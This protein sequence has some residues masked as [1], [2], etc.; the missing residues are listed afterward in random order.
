MLY[1]APPMSRDGAL[2]DLLAFSYVNRD[3]LWIHTPLPHSHLRVLS[4]A[5]KQT[6]RL[7]PEVTYLL[8][9][10]ID[11]AILV[12]SLGLVL[13]LLDLLL[14]FLGHILLLLLLGQVPLPNGREV[15]L[16]QALDDVVLPKYFSHG[17]P[18]IL[19]EG[20]LFQVVRLPHHGKRSHHFL[21]SWSQFNSHPI[22]KHLDSVRFIFGRKDHTPVLKGG[23]HPLVLILVVRSSPSL[24]LLRQGLGLFLLFQRRRPLRSSCSGFLLG[25]R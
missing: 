5:S 23:P 15:T 9:P 16:A 8:P 13:F 20:R 22:V 21:L 6:R 2:W 19:D 14:L 12:L 4:S 25:C 7:D 17:I 3:V 11:V 1:T 24:P 10:S 18:R